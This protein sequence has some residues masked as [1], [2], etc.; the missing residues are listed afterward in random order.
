[1]WRQLS[2]RNDRVGMSGTIAVDVGDRF[3]S[4]STILIDKNQIA[5]LCRPV[6]FC[7]SWNSQEYRG[8]AHPL[9][10]RC[11]LVKLQQPVVGRLRQWTGEPAAFQSHCRQL[12]L[13]FRVY[14]N[15]CLTISAALST[16]K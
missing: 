3:K 6:Y 12:V 10:P 8:F 2:L 15:Y 7:G 14:C 4:E 16:Y 13:S 9:T 11:I 5:V 1:M